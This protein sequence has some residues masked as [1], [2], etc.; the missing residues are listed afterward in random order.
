MPRFKTPIEAR[1][2]SNTRVRIKLAKIPSETKSPIPIEQWLDSPKTFSKTRFIAEFSEWLERVYG[3]KRAGYI[4]TLYFLGNEMET[5]MQAKIGFE[6]SGSELVINGR[7]NA[8]LK[9]QDIALQNI[10]RLSKELGLTPTSRLT[11]AKP[12][13]LDIHLV[14]PYPS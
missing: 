1:E 2:I 9:V 6:A 8:F 4:Y 13:A 10:L 7:Q 5:Y 14:H 11:A 12:E 3:F